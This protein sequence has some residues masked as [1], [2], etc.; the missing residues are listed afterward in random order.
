LRR[1]VYLCDVI[2]KPPA[3]ANALLN[4][5]PKD[6]QSN[7]QRVV[8]PGELEIALPNEERKVMEIMG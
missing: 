3:V 2:P 5:V 7:E 4:D 6:S 1:D 8:A